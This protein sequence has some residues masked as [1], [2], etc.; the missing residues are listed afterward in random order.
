MFVK[1]KD[2]TTVFKVKG[3]NYLRVMGR[4]EK[5]VASKHVLST[6]SSCDEVMFLYNR[7]QHSEKMVLPVAKTHTTLYDSILLV[8]NVLMM[9]D[10]INLGQVS[11]QKEH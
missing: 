4:N 5:T 7:T 6:V 2:S 9:G 10:D 3:N 11:H 8:S 1:T